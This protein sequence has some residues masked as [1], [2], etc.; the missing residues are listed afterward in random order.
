MQD[1]DTIMGEGGPNAPS[2]SEVA[3]RLAEQDLQGGGSETAS[4]IIE[5]VTTEAINDQR[6]V[7]KTFLRKSKLA[8]S[9]KLGR[10]RQQK[11]RT[12]AD[13][14]G[15]EGP[16]EAP[17]RNHP[18]ADA[19]VAEDVESTWE[20]LTRRPSASVENA[21]VDEVVKEPRV[22]PTSSRQPLLQSRDVLPEPHVV[23]GKF[24]FPIT[25]T[26]LTF[27]Y[28]VSRGELKWT[29]DGLPPTEPGL[30]AGTNPLYK[31]PGAVRLGGPPDGPLNVLW[32]TVGDVSVRHPPLIVAP[33]L[34]TLSFWASSPPP[35]N[36]SKSG[37]Y[38]SDKGILIPQSWSNWL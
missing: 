16:G 33:A 20:K 7:A 4:A 36:L 21:S 38:I 19:V 26:D 37:S 1:G 14:G 30:H 18:A 9:G 5:C 15:G 13:E 10:G 24:S 8:K 34:T 17:A 23:T 28:L 3:K 22:A 31:P 12:G 6:K 32:T 2:V 11:H 29:T 27:L 35:L 25:K